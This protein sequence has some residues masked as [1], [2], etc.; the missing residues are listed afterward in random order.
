MEISRRRLVAAMAAAPFISRIPRARGA[1]GFDPDYGS[2]SDAARAIRTG[3]ISTRELTAHVFERI[4]KYNPRVNAF[5]TLAEDQA[6]TRARAA[7]D[8]LAQGKS[9]GRLHGVPVLMKDD[10]KTA[11]I[12]ST[13][14]AKIYAENMPIE[15]AR[16]VERIRQ[17]Q[18]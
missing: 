11:G 6:M 14:G 9:W 18:L 2:A 8:A 5:V 3:A 7:D 10:K 4:H 1:A 17:L 15:N 13:C 12:R 16:A